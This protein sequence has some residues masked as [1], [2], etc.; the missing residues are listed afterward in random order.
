VRKK[1]I[2]NWNHLKKIQLALLKEAIKIFDKNQIEYFLYYGSLLGAVRHKGYIPWDDDI[3]L[4]LTRE[5]Y[6]KIKNIKIR[7][8][9]F[10]IL[11]PGAHHNYPYP[12]AKFFTTQY[13][14]AE[15][16]DCQ[17]KGLGINIDIF[18]ID[19]IPKNS[20]LKYFQDSLIFL[21]IFIINIKVVLLSKSRGKIKN[22]VHKILKK[23]FQP[24]KIGSLTYLLDKISNYPKKTNKMGCRTSIYR[25]K[26]YFSSKIFQTNIKTK[27]ENLEC[28]IP[29]KFNILLKKIYGNYMIQLPDLNKKSSRLDLNFWHEG[30]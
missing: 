5:N 13:F 18:P 30:K 8:N 20:C 16:M 29:E 9:F 25:K 23:A 6:E 3:D 26:E 11:T 12:L 4:G 19:Y 7:K 2:R 14:Y 28:A 24:I 1:K 17:F 27:F 15:K 10:K 21:L 22:F